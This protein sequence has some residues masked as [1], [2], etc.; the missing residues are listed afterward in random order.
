MFKKGYTPKGKLGSGQRFQAVSGS[1]SNEYLKKGYNPQ[2]AANIGAAVA[3]SAG[4]KA[5]GAK[6]MTTWAKAGKK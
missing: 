4:R 6:K 1:V 5:H 3:A 2:K